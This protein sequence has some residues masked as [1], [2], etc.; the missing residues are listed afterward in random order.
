MD[1]RK[2][3]RQYRVIDDDDRTHFTPRLAPLL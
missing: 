1:N 3:K 2:R